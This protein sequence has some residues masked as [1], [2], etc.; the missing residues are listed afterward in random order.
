MAQIRLYPSSHLVPCER[1]DTVLE[2][3]ERAGYALPNNCRAGACG[4]CR[5]R[6]RSGEFDQGFVLDMA[7]SAED[8]A[9][10][11]GLMCMAKLTG[12]ELEIDWGTPDARPTLFPARDDW[13]F[14]L[15]DSLPRT[16]RITE[17]VLRP[18]AEELRFWPG[19]YIRIGDPAAGVPLRSYSLATAPHP[20]GELRLHVTRLDGGFTSRWLHGLTPGAAVRV[21]GPHGT[22]VGDPSV[23]SPVLCLAAGSGLAPIRSLSEAALRRGFPYEVTVV[24]SARREED[25]YDRGLLRYWEQRHPNFH[26]VPTLTRQRVPGMCHGRIPDILGSL[27]RS[28]RDHS[29]FVAGRQDFVDACVSAVSALGAPGN[30]LHTEGFHEQ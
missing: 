20:D 19:Q 2:A 16:P 11:Y 18:L 22:F 24:F 12:D 7:L 3:L 14:V 29:V 25:L 4:E 8:R 23:C 10:G 15:V 6:V 17:L 13:P 21:S 30:L 9:A 27:V 28:L 26:Y 5:V 1:G